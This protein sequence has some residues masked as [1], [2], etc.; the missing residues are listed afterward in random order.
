MLNRPTPSPHG[1]SVHGRV[2]PYLLFGLTLLLAAGMYAWYVL[3]QPLA[4][5][6]S[7]QGQRVTVE[8]PRGSSPARGHRAAQLRALC[9]PP[10]AR[11]RNQVL[12]AAP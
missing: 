9:A 1:L 2:W 12:P 11:S 8:I 5:T 6:P 7:V 3:H 10:G 4:F